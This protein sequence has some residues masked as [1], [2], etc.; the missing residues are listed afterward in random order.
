MTKGEIIRRMNRDH[1]D[2]LREFEAASEED[3]LRLAFDRSFWSRHDCDR[4][5]FDGRCLDCGRLIRAETVLRARPF[6]PRRAG[7]PL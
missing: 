6:L 5:V 1:V 2:K 7:V 3:K 4:Y